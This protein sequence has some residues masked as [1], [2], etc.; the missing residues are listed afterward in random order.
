MV[1]ST[2]GVDGSQPP[3][4]NAQDAVG[5]LPDAMRVEVSTSRSILRW[6]GEFGMRVI[7]RLFGVYDPALLL[8]AKS[9]RA[10]P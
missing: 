2:G 10:L 7:E 4:D 9:R 5:C 1:G 8:A 6:G 3:F